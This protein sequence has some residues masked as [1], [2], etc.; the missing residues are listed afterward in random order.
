MLQIAK[1]LYT[2]FKYIP[3]M[4]KKFLALNIALLL[5][6]AYF[7]VFANPAYALG[8]SP[9]RIVVDFTPNMEGDIGFCVIN[10]ENKEMPVEYYVKGD[11]ASYIT[12]NESITYLTPKMYK[13]CTKAHY[14]LPADIASGHHDTRIGA[15]ESTISGI[16]EGTGIS[17]RVGVEMQW[18]VEAPVPGKHV[19]ASISVPEGILVGQQV[20][21]KVILKNDGK[22][23]VTVKTVLDVLSPSSG[24]LARMEFPLVE[25]ESLQSKEQLFK[26]AGTT[27]TGEYVAKATIFYEGIVGETRQQFI[28]GGLFVRITRLVI[29]RIQ[30]GGIRAIPVELQSFWNQR[31]DNVYAELNITKGGKMIQSGIKTESINL[32]PWGIAQINGYWDTTEATL[33]KYNVAVKVF[34]ANKTSQ[35]TFNFELVKSSSSGFIG[36]R[37]GLIAVLVAVNV[38][39][40]LALVVIVFIYLK[41]KKSQGSQKVA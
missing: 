18:W 6:A 31:I 30:K 3:F 8:I 32:Q 36:S 28:V 7:L 22:E 2:K 35:E 29:D 26:W 39:I 5:F 37:I 20:P 9:A 21:I 25:L 34:Y 24:S 27:I 19:S 10:N 40:V 14:K 15:V 12:L 11:L 1:G 41:G 23:K 17:A 13:Y 38:A 16:I 33:G 4:Q